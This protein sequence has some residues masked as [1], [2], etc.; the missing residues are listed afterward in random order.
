MK[1][2]GIISDTHSLLRPEAI[3]LL[4]GCDR[5][6]HAGDIGC[7]EIIE[8]LSSIA[9]VTAIKGNIDKDEWASD[10]PDSEA[11]EIGGKFIYMLHNLRDLDIDPVAAG[12]DIIISGHSHKSDIEHKDEIIYLNPGSA[13]PRR[14]KLPITLAKIEISDDNISTEIIEIVLQ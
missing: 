2:I 1:N 3:S 5:I 13:G 14:F 6:F 4:Q 8:K 12:F 10:F 11:I 9:P 7:L